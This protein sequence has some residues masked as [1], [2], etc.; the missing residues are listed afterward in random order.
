M[1]ELESNVSE[2]KKRKENPAESI[3]YGLEVPS[4]AETIYGSSDK[5]AS[6]VED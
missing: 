4:L 5:Q 2:G 6:T 1:S 3:P